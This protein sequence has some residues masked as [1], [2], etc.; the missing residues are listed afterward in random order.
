MSDY[1]I[2]PHVLEGAV[3]PPPSKSLTHRILIAE[4]LSGGDLLPE[5]GTE[6]EDIAATRRCLK[7]LAAPGEGLPVLD[8]GESG[9]TLRF[10]LPLALVLRGGGIFHGAGRLLERPMRP[11]EELCRQK[12]VRYEQGEK[13]LTVEGKPAP[14]LFELPGNVSSQFVTGLLFALP[15]LAGESRI[16]LTTALESTPYVEM[17]TGVLDS[18]GVEITI[19]GKD[20]IVTGNQ[21]YKENKMEPEADWSQGAFWYAANFLDHHITLEGLDPQSRQGDRQIAL[22]YWALAR[23]GD[24]ELDMSQHPDLL[25]AAALMASARVGKTRLTH[26]R[27]LRDKESDRLTATAVTLKKLGASVEETEDGLLLEGPCRLKGG[28]TL[29]SFGDHRIAMLAAI[30]AASCDG[31]VVLKNG[32][33]VRKSYPAFWEHYSSLGGKYDVLVS[34]Q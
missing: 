10:L 28:A 12:G 2:Y 29:D 24:V 26:A 11:Y 27:R 33:C 16:R 32:D 1:K 22:W 19:K 14:G 8:C 3:T 25:P 15:L 23:P 5:D 18:F 6:S 34:G 20:F 17:T 21:K 9:S 4:F 30:G 13:R 7:A 31:P